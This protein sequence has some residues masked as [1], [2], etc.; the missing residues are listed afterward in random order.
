MIQIILTKGSIDI[1]GGDADEI[2][3]NELSTKVNEALRLNVL[4]DIG[5]KYVNPNHIITIVKL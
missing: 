3:M 1:T 4:L 5:G 2:N